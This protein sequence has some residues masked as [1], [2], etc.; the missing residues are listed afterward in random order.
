MENIKFCYFL[1]Y[2]IV[3]ILIII[4]PDN[5]NKKLELFKYIN[6]LSLLFIFSV[7]III[8]QLINF[9]YSLGIRYFY[10]K[11]I[12]RYLETLDSNEKMALIDI[13]LKNN[14]Q[15]VYTHLGDASAISLLAKKLILKCKN[16]EKINNDPYIIPHFVW[17]KLKKMEKKKNNWVVDL[18]KTIESAEI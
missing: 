11:D 9:F 18:L 6:I 1:A 15:T 4:V 5:I 10:E 13:G 17:N 3:Y 16:D 7:V 8:G 12:L 2:L 14:Q